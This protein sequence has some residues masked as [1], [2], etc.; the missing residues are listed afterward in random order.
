MPGEM[1]Q[2]SLGE[3]LPEPVLK[4]LPPVMNR[5]RDGKLDA[6]SGRKELAAILEPERANLLAK[7]V[8]LEYLAYYLIHIAL[9]GEGGDLGGAPLN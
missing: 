7:G 8:L 6:I 2:A 5:I 1:R 9:S 3:L 4:K